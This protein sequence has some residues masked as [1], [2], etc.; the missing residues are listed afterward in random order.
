[1]QLIVIIVG[2]D[3]AMSVKEKHLVNVHLEVIP[4]VESKMD[5]I[6]AVYLVQMDVPHNKVQIEIV[7]HVG[8]VIKMG[9]VLIVLI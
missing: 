8:I 4:F 3:G 6:V 1:M 9:D 2:N 5:K 7:S